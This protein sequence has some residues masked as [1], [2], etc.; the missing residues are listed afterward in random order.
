MVYPIESHR[1]VKSNSQK[2]VTLKNTIDINT[3]HKSNP[4]RF[5]GIA[6]ILV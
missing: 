1:I 5:E 6:L 3:S 2:E 4:I